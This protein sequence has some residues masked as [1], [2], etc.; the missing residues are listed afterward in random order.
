MTRFPNATLSLTSYYLSVGLRQN[1]GHVN[2]VGGER[3]RPRAARRS[4]LTVEGLRPG[5]KVQ[6]V[7]GSA[8]SVSFVEQPWEAFLCIPGWILAVI[9]RAVC[10]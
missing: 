8:A 3:L 4:P 2:A 6:G 5:L 1:K 9:T 7:F 10:N